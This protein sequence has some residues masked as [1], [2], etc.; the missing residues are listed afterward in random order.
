MKTLMT[1]D[2]SLIAPKF[3]MV[4][5]RKDVDLS[6]NIRN[7]KFNLPIISAN[8]DTVTDANFAS[9]MLKN[10]AQA[11]LHRF[12]SIQDTVN[13]FLS[14]SHGPAS[15]PMVSIGLGA[16]ELE[17]A[18][19]LFS[20]GAHTFVIDVAHGGQIS[21]VNQAKALRELLGPYVNI[22][23]GN[24]ATGESV[25]TFLEHSG[26]IVDGIKVGIGPGSAC[27]T[28]IK[29]G[30][31][32]PQLSAII[33]ISNTLKNTNIVVIA[34]GGMKNPGDVAK[35]LGAGAH[36]AMLGGMLA[37]TDESPGEYVNNQGHKLTFLNDGTIKVDEWV[38]H[39][40]NVKIFKKYRGSAS[41]ESYES[42]GKTAEHRTS[43]G[44]SFMVPHKGPVKNILQ[45]IEGG[46]RSSFS[47]VG[48][49]NLKEFH[50]NVE[51]VKISNAGYIEGTPHG[52]K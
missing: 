2:D 4:E 21:V 23:V 37:A 12:G 9:A 8:M 24:F 29:T 18:Q 48:A 49:R 28:R 45:D 5:S 10:G 36:M 11:C 3:S 47:Y 34:D 26:N 42:Q 19:A 52:K 35:S 16:S 46:L 39:P 44:A 15:S 20:V 41:Q 14:S 33:D 31:G 50:A 32:V 25:R 27:E 13:S 43:E 7:L 6:T 1:F 22:V 40:N 51:F 17:R 30:I 38:T